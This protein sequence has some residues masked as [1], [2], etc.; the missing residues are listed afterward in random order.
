MFSRTSTPSPWGIPSESQAYMNHTQT[1]LREWKLEVVR[2]NTAHV[3]W[4]CS[5]Q[6]FHQQMKRVSK[7]IEKEGENI[8]E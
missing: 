2:L 4:S 8:K 5:V 6:G 7:L 3:V 1:N